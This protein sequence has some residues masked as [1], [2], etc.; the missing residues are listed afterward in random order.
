[1][2]V[3]IADPGL[4]L[5][6]AVEAVLRGEPVIAMQPVFDD[7]LHESSVGAVG[8]GPARAADRDVGKGKRLHP[9]HDGVQLRLADFDL[10]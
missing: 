9:G 4:E 10:E 5:R 7:V 2:D 8:P 1:M 6:E 3:E